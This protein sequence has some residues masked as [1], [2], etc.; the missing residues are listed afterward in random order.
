MSIRGHLRHMEWIFSHVSL[1]KKQPVRGQMG[2]LKWNGV[3][4]I[5]SEDPRGDV[6]TADETD[7]IFTP[8]SRTF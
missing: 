8:S 4:V 6:D 3:L 2:R 1:D 7:F 5:R